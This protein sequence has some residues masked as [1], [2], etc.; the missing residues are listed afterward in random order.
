MNNED[1]ADFYDDF[2]AKQV[3]TGA[4]ERLISLYKRLLKMGL[5]ATSTVLELGCG[6]GNFTH[7]LAQKVNSGNIEAVD[8]S[9]KSISI[10]KSK[11]KSQK[12]ILFEVADIVRYNPKSSNFD[13]ISLMDV[14]EHIPLDQHDHLFNNIA[15]ICTENT[16]ITIN[17]PNPEYI[18]YT[19]ENNPETLQV[20]DQEVH[21]LPL[22]KIIEKNDLEL[23]FFEKYGIWEVEDYHFLVIRKKRNFELKHL[24][25]QRKISEKILKKVSRKIDTVKYR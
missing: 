25:D 17:I 1:I 12:N 3:T 19:C 21:L 15:G 9:E 24:A 10:A 4:N 23:V 16:L 11:F 13:F 5:K 20:I 7:L 22:L 6:V 14:V 18:R 8:L 2:S